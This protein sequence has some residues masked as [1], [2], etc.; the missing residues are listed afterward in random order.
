MIQQWNQFPQKCYESSQ[1]VVMSKFPVLNIIEKMFQKKTTSKSENLFWKLRVPKRTRFYSCCFIAVCSVLIKKY[2]RCG[3]FR[4]NILKFPSN[5]H[6]FD[7]FS[8][9][10]TRKMLQKSILSRR[11]RATRYSPYRMRW[12]IILQPKCP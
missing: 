9:L 5:F 2:R 10:F 7:F 4:A 1:I 6:R 11:E 8:H 3:N 12:G